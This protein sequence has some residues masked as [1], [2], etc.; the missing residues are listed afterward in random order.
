[1]LRMWPCSAYCFRLDLLAIRYQTLSVRLTRRSRLF[2]NA[3]AWRVRSGPSC[4]SRRVLQRERLWSVPQLPN[5]LS[6]LAWQGKLFSRLGSCPS[7]VVPIGRPKAPGTEGRLTPTPAGGR[8]WIQMQAVAGWDWGHGRVRCAR[9]TP[10]VLYWPKSPGLHTHHVGQI[11]GTQPTMSNTPVSIHVPVWE[12]CMLGWAV[13][14]PPILSF[15]PV[16]C[17]FLKRFLWGF[18]EI[19]I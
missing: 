2:T 5:C 4:G 6:K 3:T 13:M 15:S 18:S 9:P 16:V 11:P 12:Q 1:M 14:F 17:F 7:A 10:D 8:E 19:Y